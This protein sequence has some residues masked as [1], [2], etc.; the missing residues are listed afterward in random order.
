MK[1]KN[2]FNTFMDDPRAEREEKLFFNGT[3]M[4]VHNLY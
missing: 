1:K 4:Q 2:R 3:A